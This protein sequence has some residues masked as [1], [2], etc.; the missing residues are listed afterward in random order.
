MINAA[1][2]FTVVNDF[3]ALN[4]REIKYRVSKIVD[5]GLA[6]RLDQQSPRDWEM[7]QHPG[8]YSIQPAPSR[9]PEVIFGCG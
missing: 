7:G 5:F 1:G 3:G 9:A 8:I 6:T 4:L 2:P